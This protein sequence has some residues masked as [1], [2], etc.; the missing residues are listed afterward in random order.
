MHP[1]GHPTT[2]PPMP[3]LG[4]AAPS[5]T[6]GHA[7]AEP[8]AELGAPPPGHRWAS[9][10]IPGNPGSVAWIPVPEHDNRPVMF[11]SEASLNSTVAGIRER[12]RVNTAGTPD[13]ARLALAQAAA[14]DLDGGTIAVAGVRV[15]PL[16]V[17]VLWAFEAS[18]AHLDIITRG[19]QNAETAWTWLLVTQPRK[20]FDL[21]LRGAWE[22]IGDLVA[23]AAIETP[24][25]TAQRVDAWF[26]AE[27]E[28]LRSIAGAGA[29][30]GAGEAVGKP[31]AAPSPQSAS[32]DPPPAGP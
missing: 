21:V 15:C 1:E 27:L 32:A 31:W 3:G 7:P 26:S 8:P 9:K 2:L 29:S 28:R 14:A 17:G 13:E 18:I 22:E 16:S 4:P 23:R 30:E 11:E 6:T 24:A 20:V 5:P 12:E 10:T 19:V 25:E